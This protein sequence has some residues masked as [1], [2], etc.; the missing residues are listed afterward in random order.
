MLIMLTLIVFVCFAVVVHRQL[1]LNSCV[2]QYS[3]CTQEVKEL[4]KI[5]GECDTCKK[6]LEELEKCRNDYS[7]SSLEVKELTKIAGEWGTCKKQL[8]ELEKC[9]NDLC[10]L[11]E[12]KGK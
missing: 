7:D 1:E 9:R 10:D 12:M 11:R 6:Q 4:S 5:R 2:A 8:E 3:N